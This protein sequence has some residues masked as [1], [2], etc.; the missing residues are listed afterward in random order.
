[1]SSEDGDTFRSR[2][3]MATLVEAPCVYKKTLQAHAWIREGGCESK[4]TC[5]SCGVI[6]IIIV[7]TGR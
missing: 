1:M 2:G 3:K 6:V 7:K 5:A 4:G